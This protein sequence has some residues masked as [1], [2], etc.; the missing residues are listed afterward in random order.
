MRLSTTVEV[1]RPM[2]PGVAIS[3]TIAMAATFLSDHHGGP[4]LL[5]ALL[6]GMSLN[7][8]SEGSTAAPGIQL[9]GQTVLRIG[10]AMLGVRISTGQIVELGVVPIAIVVG[11][12]LATLLFGR[13]AATCLELTPSQGVL[14]GGAV[15]ICGASAALAISAV[16]PKTK[17]TESNTL[18]TVIIV[19]LLGTITMIIYPPLIRALGLSHHAAGILIGGTIH[20]VAQVVGA[21]YLVSDEAGIVATYI[22]LL[23]VAMLAP[24]VTVL[25]WTYTHRAHTSAAGTSPLLPGFLLAFLALAV[26]NSLGLVSGR[27]AEIM[28]Q[29]SRWCLVSA[30]A[31]LGM[32]T[33][34]QELARV[35]WR[36]LLLLVSETIFLF[37]FVFVALRCAGLA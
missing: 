8:L 24:V 22:K 33:S 3:A 6:I 1:V 11:G 37:V 14:T 21:G 26:A 32:K 10:V 29:V 16:L 2:V 34:L 23:R 12:V 15:A 18:F 19:T 25:A 35:G 7:F 28:G 9:V 30:I 17:D 5:Y 4:V 27:A 20:D 31:A 36:P 13:Y